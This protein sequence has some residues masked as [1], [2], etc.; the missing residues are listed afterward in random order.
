MGKKKLKRELETLRAQLEHPEHHPDC[1][2]EIEDA[3][4]R[5]LKK[6]HMKGFEAGQKEIT[7]ETRH[8]ILWVEGKRLYDQ[9]S[10]TVGLSVLGLAMR[11]VPV[12]DPRRKEYNKLYKEGSH[13][14]F[15]CA[16]H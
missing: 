3:Y 16:E 1:V 7:D 9:G 6:G 8:Q 10:W 4:L 15:Y 13:N 5:G 12:G 14:A 11:Y 2:K